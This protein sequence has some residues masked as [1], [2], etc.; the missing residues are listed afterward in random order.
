M[1][2]EPVSFL[3][4]FRRWK[5]PRSCFFFPLETDA[6]KLTPNRRFLLVRLATKHRRSC[7]RHGLG[8]PRA[9]VPTRMGADARFFTYPM[10]FSVCYGAPGSPRSA[11]KGRG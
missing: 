7:A 9:A 2:R 10:R 5:A 4:L 11:G 8:Q 1:W 3:A 6:R